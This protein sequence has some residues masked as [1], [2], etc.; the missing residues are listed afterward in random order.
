MRPG[1]RSSGTPQDVRDAAVQRYLTSGLSTR[2]VAME[3]GMTKSTIQVWVAAAGASVMK[4]GKHKRV[5]PPRI[6]TDG[7]SAQKKLE[8]LI[9][10][11]RL[12]D[13]ELGEYLRAQGLTEG[14][15]ERYRLEALGGLGGDIHNPVDS[16]RIE[17]LERAKSKQEARLREAEALLDLQKKVHALWDTEG[18]SSTER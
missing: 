18:K 16:R 12:S 11:G 8:A 14:D 17:E 1:F 2:E 3:F 6:A 15:L 10:A 13:D 9:T 4:N 7:R 5:D